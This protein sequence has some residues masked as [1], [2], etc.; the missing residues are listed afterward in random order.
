MSEPI[1]VFGVFLDPDDRHASK[2]GLVVRS[3]VWSFKDA[4]PHIQADRGRLLAFYSSDRDG[5]AGLSFFHPQRS[6]LIARRYCFGFCA[7]LTLSV[8]DGAWEHFVC[9]AC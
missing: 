4:K 2:H 6:W 9:H 7:L 8:I 5:K 1:E 3:G